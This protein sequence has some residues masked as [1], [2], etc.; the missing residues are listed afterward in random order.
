MGGKKVKVVLN[1]GYSLKPNEEYV[2]FIVY[3]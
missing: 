3:V 1:I 2:L